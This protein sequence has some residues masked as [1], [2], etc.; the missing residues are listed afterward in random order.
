MF[1]TD[2]MKKI[3]NERDYKV[4]FCNGGTECDIF[5][6]SHLIHTLESKYSLYNWMCDCWLL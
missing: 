6:D 5:M 4:Y 2:E 3:L 1:Y